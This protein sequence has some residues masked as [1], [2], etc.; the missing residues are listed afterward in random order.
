MKHVAVIAGNE[1]PYLKT[2]RQK[3]MTAENTFGI[4][5]KSFL[6]GSLAMFAAAG[7]SG[8]AAPAKKIQGFD[9]TNAGKLAA[10]VGQ[11]FCDR[12][13]GGGFYELPRVDNKEAV[14]LSSRKLR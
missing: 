11:F 5:R 3:T 14:C 12:S 10:K 7:A 8:A 13:M 4:S 1:F 9:E 2:E 6:G